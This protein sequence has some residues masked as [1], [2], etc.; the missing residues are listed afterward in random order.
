AFE[1][2]PTIRISELN[3]G[4][5]SA[6]REAAVELL[7][8][9]NRKIRMLDPMEASLQRAEQ[10]LEAGDLRTAERH[11]LAVQK[12][13]TSTSEQVERAAALARSVEQRRLELAPTIPDALAQAERDFLAGRY[14]QARAGFQDVERSGVRLTADQ[15]AMLDRYQLKLVDL[16]SEDPSIFGTPAVAGVMQ[17]GTVRRR[18]EQPPAPAPAP[19]AQP[20]QPQQP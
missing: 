13:A 2:D 1:E 16:A 14:A 6:N 11:A 10:A 8:E 15:T 9:A 12:N 3:R 4:E 17:P 5:P 19:A 7:T 20:E 18:D